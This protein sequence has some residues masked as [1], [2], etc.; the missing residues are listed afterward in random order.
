ME[1]KAEELRICKR[2]LTRDMKEQE[3]YFRSLHEYIDNLDPDI[4]AAA[5][6]YE[7]RLAL[8]RECELLFEGMCRSC[9]C[10]VELRAA[11]E[12]NACPWKKW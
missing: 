10:Y 8:C 7:E 1:E 11:I 6:L 5:T 3:E 2:C 12:K 9:G 4:K